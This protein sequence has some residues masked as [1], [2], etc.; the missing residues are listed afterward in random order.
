MTLLNFKAVSEDGPEYISFAVQDDNRLYMMTKNYGGKGK[1]RQISASMDPAKAERL[2]VILSEYITRKKD[3]GKDYES[4]IHDLRVK[5]EMFDKLMGRDE[6]ELLLIFNGWLDSMRFDD[7]LTEDQ[8][9]TCWEMLS[10]VHR[11]QEGE[12]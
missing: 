2:M 11:I 5:A 6:T 7:R 9:N 8:Q 1:E 4:Y 10:I 12:I 3:K